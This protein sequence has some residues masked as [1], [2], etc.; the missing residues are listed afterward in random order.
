[1]TTTTDLIV[2]L[3]KEIPDVDAGHALLALI[4]AR[5]AQYPDV[6]ITAHI[7]Q[8]IQAEDPT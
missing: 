6:I 7:T 4:K 5:L 3:R 8:H 1:M 2:T